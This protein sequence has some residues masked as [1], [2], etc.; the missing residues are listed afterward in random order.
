MTTCL[1]NWCGF[2]DVEVSGV[3][4]WRLIGVM[5]VSIW[6]ATVCSVSRDVCEV[7]TLL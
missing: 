3:P 2:I 1:D 5:S 4:Q 6:A 7:L